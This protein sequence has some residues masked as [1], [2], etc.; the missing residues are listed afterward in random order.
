M[1]VRNNPPSRTC[2]RNYTPPQTSLA[3]STTSRNFA[4]CDSTAMSLPCTVDEKPH[5]GDSASYSS[6]TSFAAMSM[7]RFTLSLLSSC[8][9][10]VLTRP[11]TTTLPG[12]TWRSGAKSP[13]RASSYSRK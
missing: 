2:F 10:F 7:R 8:P 4:V 3:V 9:T 12:G 5:C 6:G 13:E 1:R 11:S